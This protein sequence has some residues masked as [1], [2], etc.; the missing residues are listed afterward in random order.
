MRGRTRQPWRGARKITGLCAGL[1]LIA[2][3][4]GTHPALAQTADS[5]ATSG[6]DKSGYTLFNP[7]PDD[8]MRGFCTDRP[9]KAD[10]ACTVDAGHFQYESDMFNWTHAHNGS[11]TVDTY[12][13]PNPT[14]KLGLT[15]RVDLELN[16]APV[17]T[18][19]TKGA[20]GKQSATGIGDLFVATKVNVAGPD[21]GAFQAAILPYVKIPTAKPGI[22][23]GA[24]EGGVSAQTSTILSPDFTLQIGPEL[25]IQ[26]NTANA[27]MHPNFQLPVN[28]N[29]AVSSSVTAYVELWGQLD[30]DPTAAAKQVSFTPEGTGTPKG[31]SPTAASKQASFD[32]ALS[33]VAW[34]DLPN[35][36]LDIG[37]NIGLTS[38]TPRIQVYTGIAQRF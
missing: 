36:Q 1:L 35:L 14:L 11:R 20:L 28:L 8:Q 19:S 7:T 24:V 25:D 16:M 12:L 15:N 3:S 38:G 31:G 17:E 26:H 10:F 5:E 9:I 18:V 13:Y 34:S 32:L 27:G 30:N 21:G 2:A 6:P 37:T 4:R 33:W 29:Y 22:G 23:N